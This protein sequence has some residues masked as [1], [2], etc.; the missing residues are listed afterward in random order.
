VEI[1]EQGFAAGLRGVKLHC[2][3]QCIGPDDERMEEIYR[4]CQEQ[5]QPLV[6]HAG[7]E[8]AS[9]AYKCD[10]YEL[11]SAERIEA[12]LSSFPKL[13][14]CVPHLGADEFDAYERLITRF[15]NLYLDTTMAVAEYFPVPTPVRL[16][17]ARPDRILYGTDFPNLPYAWDREVRKLAQLKLPEHD[18]AALLGSNVLDLFR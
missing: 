11:C 18:L 13:K 5:G 16:I 10:P 7:R 15:D 4:L 12:V 3:V 2:H 14:L 8:P 1:L 6:M 9:P 17:Q